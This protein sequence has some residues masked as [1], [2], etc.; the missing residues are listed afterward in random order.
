[1]EPTTDPPTRAALAGAVAAHGLVL[2]GG[3]VPAPVDRVP[4]LRDGR[5]PAVVWLVGQFGS[6]CWSSFAASPEAR[7]G[8]PDPMDR[9]ARAIAESLARRWSGA[10]LMP[11]EG[12]PFHPFQRWAA[13][14]EGVGCSPIGLAMH[15]TAGLWHAYRFALAMPWLDPRDAGAL[16]PD[17]AG[18][19]AA[20]APPLAELCRRCEGQP[21]LTAC[22]VQAFSGDSRYDVQACT[23]HLRHPQ[24]ADCMTLGCRARRACPVGAAERYAPEHAGFHMRAFLRDA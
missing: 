11:S 23:T 14:A 17:G 3:F 5:A 24:G 12:P 20:A 8:R 13:R 1:M 2:R 22:P 16:A 7:D 21:C 9:W 15:P 10:V 19:P 18:P 4:P 6:R